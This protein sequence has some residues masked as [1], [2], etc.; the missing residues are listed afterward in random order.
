MRNN[1][2]PWLH[3]KNYNCYTLHN[4]HTYIYITYNRK[5]DHRLFELYKNLHSLNLSIQDNVYFILK[6]IVTWLMQKALLNI[7]N[8]AI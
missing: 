6:L 8:K 5:T 1:K 4:I 7:G 3:L 2:Y